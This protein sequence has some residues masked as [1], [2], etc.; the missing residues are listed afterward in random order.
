MAILGQGVRPFNEPKT[1]RR[2]GQF[3]VFS[4][5]NRHRHTLTNART[6][7]QS[8]QE[9]SITPNSSRRS[10]SATVA[11]APPL[12]VI[13]RANIIPSQIELVPS[14]FLRVVPPPSSTLPNCI[15][16][17]ALKVSCPSVRAF[18]LQNTRRS[19][20]S[21]LL[22]T[23]AP[24]EIKLYRVRA[25]GKARVAAETRLEAALSDPPLPDSVMT[26]DQQ[27]RRVRAEMRRRNHLSALLSSGELSPL[28]TLRL[29]GGE[30]MKI[31]V[32]YRM[33][34]RTWIGGRFTNAQGTIQIRMD[35]FDRSL[36]PQAPA[37]R[38]PSEAPTL[39]IP[40]QAK[41]CEVRIALSQTSINFGEIEG[42]SDGGATRKR[43]LR[44]GNPSDVPLLYRLEKTGS[45]SSGDLRFPENLRSGVV[46]P[47]AEREIPFEFAPSFPGTFRERVTLVNV[48]DPTANAVV[49]VKAKVKQRVNFWLRGLSL[50]FG[51]CVSGQPSELRR[52]VIKNVTNRERSFVITHQKSS[53]SDATEYKSDPSGRAPPLSPRGGPMSPPRAPKSPV[54][55]PLGTPQKDAHRAGPKGPRPV[56]IFRMAERQALGT[57]GEVAKQEEERERLTLKLRVAIRK[58]KTEKIKKIT[59][60]LAALGRLLEAEDRIVGG[61]TADSA[62]GR[63]GGGPSSGAE[64]EVSGRITFSLMANAIQVIHVRLVA[65]MDT[66]EGVDVASTARLA[67]TLS[68][69]EKKNRDVIKEVSFSADIVP[70]A[71]RLVANLEVR[72][73]PKPIKV[74]EAPDSTREP[75]LSPIPLPF[76]KTTSMTSF[77]SSKSGGGR[78]SSPLST[79]S[80]TL[81]DWEDRIIEARES[82]G[83]PPLTVTIPRDFKP[84]RPPRFGHTRD[85]PVAEM[86]VLP[87]QSGE[88]MYV[89]GVV[90]LRQ[91]TTQRFARV[92]LEWKDAESKR[93]AGTGQTHATVTATVTPTVSFRPFLAT[94]APSRDVVSG[95]SGEE[96]AAGSLQAVLRGTQRHFVNF[97]IEKKTLNS[98]AVGRQDGALGGLIVF[99]DGIPCALVKVLPRP[100]AWPFKLSLAAATTLQNQQLDYDGRSSR[101]LIVRLTRAGGA[102]V[103][104]LALQLSAEGATGGY[105][106]KA[107]FDEPANDRENSVT[108]P[109]SETSKDGVACK[110]LI[111]FSR[112]ATAPQHMYFWLALR[113]K[114]TGGLAAPKLRVNA[115]TL[116]AR[117]VSITRVESDRKAGAEAMAG[118]GDTDGKMDSVDLGGIYFTPPHIAQSTGTTQG[119][120]SAMEV[121]HERSRVATVLIVRSLRPGATPIR[122]KTTSLSPSQVH[123]FADAELSKKFPD[124]LNLRRGE[125]A[126]VF[127]VVRPGLTRAA[128]ISGAC[129]SFASAIRFEVL[130]GRNGGVV[131]ARVIQLRGRVAMALMAVSVGPGSDPV[132]LG[133][134]RLVPGAVD[135][136]SGA[137]GACP[138]DMGR[139]E[140]LGSEA[141][142]TIR[143]RN[144][145]RGLPLRFEVSAD[146]GVRVTPGDTLSP[147]GQN[148]DERLITAHV[149]ATH[150]GLVQRCIHV[151]NLCAAEPLGRLCITARL[152]VDPKAISMSAVS[153]GLTARGDA[154]EAKATTTTISQPLQ[155]FPRKETGKET[156]GLSATC[157]LGTVYVYAM[158]SDHFEGLDTNTQSEPHASAHQSEQDTQTESD[159]QHDAAASRLGP[160]NGTAGAK[161]RRRPEPDDDTGA[162]ISDSDPDPSDAHTQNAESTPVAQRT[163]EGVPSWATALSLRE[164]SSSFEDSHGV[165]RP[166][167]WRKISPD[168]DARQTGDNESDSAESTVE[169]ESHR[170]QD[171]RFTDRMRRL[172]GLASQDAVPAELPFAARD[173]SRAEMEMQGNE[174]ELKSKGGRGGPVSV[175]AVRHSR[176]VFR[177]ENLSKM[178]PITVR[179][180][181]SNP[182]LSVV[183]K[184]DSGLP[185]STAART[186]TSFPDPSPFDPS[187]S[188]VT[189]EPGEARHFTVSYRH[190]AA[191][192]SDSLAFRRLLRGEKVN[193]R[194]LLVLESPDVVMAP[195][196]VA[197]STLSSA[198]AAKGHMAVAA[199]VV[200]GALC[201]SRSRVLTSQFDVGSIGSVNKWRDVSLAV[202]IKNL[203]DVPLTLRIRQTEKAGPVSLMRSSTENQAPTLPL[204][205]SKRGRGSSNDEDGGNDGR[206]N[207]VAS[208]VTT[209]AGG[210]TA[211][212]L[213]LRTSAIPV[214]PFE[215][216]IQLENT[217]NQSE[218]HTV[219]VRG[220]VLDRLLAFNRLQSRAEGFSGPGNA[221]RALV[222]P[223]IELPGTAARPAQAEEWFSIRNLTDSRCEL[224]IDVGIAAPLAALVEMAVI[225][226]SANAPL[227]ALLLHSSGR[228]EVRVRCAVRAGVSSDAVR[229]ALAGMAHSSDNS[230][231]DRESLGSGSYASVQLGT[232]SLRSAGADI[233]ETIEILGAFDDSQRSP[234]SGAQRVGKPGSVSPEFMA[235]ATGS[236]RTPDATALG[237]P[238]KPQ[239]DENDANSGEVENVPVAPTRKTVMEFLTTSEQSPNTS[240]RGLSEA[241]LRQAREQVKGDAAAVPRRLVSREDALRAVSA[242]YQD[243]DSSMNAADLLGQLQRLISGE[244]GA[245]K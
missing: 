110:A 82:T 55:S 201:L 207:D 181:S 190:T 30:K 148:G 72:R 183:W 29:A 235:L 212:R 166:W 10:E 111:Q 105:S 50:D 7:V 228:T 23:S 139:V 158:D 217:N 51:R 155:P 175:R 238:A 149:R 113:A 232:V 62:P 78:P 116:F 128:R 34:P 107:S 131:S 1:A 38:A 77:A 205:D 4:R 8:L 13:V 94:Q 161:G 179:P 141:C 60:R 152:F 21:L 220:R 123:L 90:V 95:S 245:S 226:R 145:T 127:V 86:C 104:N 68:V 137:L 58:K 244:Q 176:R 196:V 172:F 18:G 160:Q 49:K 25:E 65:E 28:E 184:G 106:V 53:N 119:D 44:L 153:D 45:V 102:Q 188:G 69:H 19:S 168:R 80:H 132:R 63:G 85:A 209:G 211:L 150:F 144:R 219:S 171:L 121:T 124:V 177:V 98:C 115:S 89:R 9:Q 6:P 11:R 14:F 36:L 130:A 114:G 96:W 208:T 185:A 197:D 40:L 227:S 84:L 35:K 43:T 135:P 41:V 5:D 216:T 162:E 100:C 15:N 125:P 66:R 233:E 97:R 236:P 189:L 112:P 75:T 215:F 223:P 195:G 64:K 59:E 147:R 191:L 2:M 136:N 16:F 225:G 165:L 83:G 192:A 61:D 194:A 186:T 26:A 159:A 52:I 222:L 140:T 193:F 133:P 143:I 164:G 242:L 79:R 241:K 122:L 20:L 57:A 129:R 231:G 32:V 234:G 243:P 187:A 202:P 74:P 56:I 33:S 182:G 118:T 3:S 31:F 206:G 76:R 230:T 154:A 240:G 91:H 204:Q 101:H 213:A 12:K 178:R 173:R 108:I 156:G 134:D 126:R 117:Y 167:L 22:S 71:T 103:E 180:K 99:L 93:A 138:I 17:G 142:V 198:S 210:T 120:V 200:C 199:L 214:G 174:K 88:T 170:L 73:R 46:R 224:E 48:L 24:E 39:T 54:Q 221:A 203:S 81:G 37:P 67:G 47:L 237:A 218:I 239:G 42:L 87:M 163:R 109:R 92:R 70:S 27:K 151:Q 169:S 229:A 146:A 157:D